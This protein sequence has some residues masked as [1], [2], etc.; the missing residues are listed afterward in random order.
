MESIEPQPTQTQDNFLT[1]PGLLKVMNRKDRVLSREFAYRMGKNGTIPSYWVKRKI[2]VRLP[3][4]LDAL[5]ANG[6]G[7]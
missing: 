6:N 4:V 1:V 7:E 2:F 5:R 3:E